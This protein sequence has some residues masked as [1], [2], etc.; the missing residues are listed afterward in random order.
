M[1]HADGGHPSATRLAAFGL[2]QLSA[3]ESALIEQHL[4]SCDSCWQQAGGLT[5][6]SLAGILNRSA[7]GTA[8]FTNPLSRAAG[9]PRPE[10]SD[11]AF[12]EPGG[13]EARL[14]AELTDHM[15][16]RV[17]G[18]L[19]FGGMGAVFKAEHRLMERP[20]ALKVI[21]QRLLNR[22][23]AVERFRREVKAAA[24]LNH[25]N[26]V[27]AYDA[28][29][30]GPLHFL[31]MEFVPGTSLARLVADRGPLS[32]REACD[33]VRQ[34]ALGL[35]HAHEHG[36]VHRDIKPQNLML[37]PD[38]QIKILDFGLAHFVSE[39]DRPPVPGDPE[40]AAAP[41][42]LDA[43]PGATQDVEG[44]D[45]GVSGG[46]LTSVGGVVGSP[47][48]IA[49]EQ[50]L[51]AHHADVRADI[52]SLGCT[53]YFLL[54]GRPPFAEGS[55]ADKLAAH[56]TQKPKALT[57]AR[58]GMP[59]SLSHVLDRMLA[60][61]PT[62]RYQ[63]PAEVVRALAP[64]GRDRRLRRRVALAVAGAGFLTVAALMAYGGIREGTNL[65]TV[66]VENETP[67]LQLQIVQD[68]KTVRV[69]DC[70][71]E[72]EARIK[73][74]RYEFHLLPEGMELTVSPA[75]AVLERDQ[76]V[77]VH[78]R[79]MPIGL[80]REMTHGAAVR[81]VAFSPDG[82]RGL[83]GDDGGAIRLW[84]LRTGQPVRNFTAQQSGSVSRVAFL[85]DGRQCLSASAD[86]LVR[87]WDADTGKE[88]RRFTGHTGGVQ[89][90]LLS[91]GGKK[92][93]SAGQDKVIREWDLESGKQL[94]TLEG[95]T[96]LVA[97]LALSSD[98]RRLLSGGNDLTIRLWDLASR[99]ELRQFH[100]HTGPVNTVA[101][102]PDGRRAVSA[103]GDTT[104]AVWDLE[105]GR[106]L[107]LLEL[108][109]S[110]LLAMALSPDGRFLLVGAGWQRLPTGFWEQSTESLQLWELETGRLV[111]YGGNAAVQWRVAFSPDGRYA[112]SGS[113]DRSMRLW[114]LP[115]PGEREGIL[116][117]PEPFV[118]RTLDEGPGY[119]R[120]FRGQ[121]AEVRRLDLSPGDAQLLSGGKDGTIQLFD[122]AT[123]R[124]LREWRGH[125]GGVLAVACAREGRHAL[126]GGADRLV[127]LWDIANG[128]ELRQFAG[129]ADPVRAVALS[130][131][132]KF[133]LSGGG[134]DDSEAK[135]ATDPDLRL[136]DVAAGT[137]VGRLKGHTDSVEHV[138]FSPDGK[139]AVS[140]GLDRAVRL[141]DVATRTEL[142]TL[143]HPDKVHGAAWSPDSR[144]IV[145][146]C[147]DGSLRL[148]DAA[149]GKEERVLGRHPGPVL[150]ATF[151][152]NGQRVVSICP[153]DGG[154]TLWESAT[155]K[156]LY[157]QSFAG[158][159]RPSCAVFTRNGRR[160]VMGTQ[161]GITQ[162]WQLP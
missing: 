32:V 4:M 1:Q 71:R 117:P 158:G 91:P 18:L 49:P 93:Y 109:N 96:D 107:R 148:W 39:F 121:W 128:E 30:V 134:F 72:T 153:V 77:T 76:T 111:R 110:G 81:A 51:D 38:G 14:P 64:F 58:S 37:T 54:T 10:V 42:A 85:P 11:T 21:S 69:L 127:R 87:L 60:K 142:R 66:R 73:P 151:S 89:D 137:E 101:F 68:E 40:A 138:A 118:S 16:Y 53:L 57:A 162:A 25:P 33:Y 119:V 86:R 90:V 145:S 144:K 43:D 27:A 92:L 61:D 106:R 50:I 44:N 5:Q 8:E 88:I 105:T 56:R 19:G 70:D 3:E 45:A 141:W 154:L 114:R 146:A 7:T 79:P 75:L 122:F 156:R 115:D 136:W 139:Q 123:G 15:R 22:P 80:V 160:V 74:G 47:D 46:T 59:S 108:Q 95:H 2:G 140:A 120:Q 102:L 98:G 133:A 36:M 52:Y 26:I 6:D 34:A 84:D 116:K 62:K 94:G 147:R 150:W 41:T 124:H 9:P 152:P 17:E 159:G 55:F 23:T 100:G 129:H 67:G 31:V 78:I 24:R 63:T 126:S 104:I 99:K 113:S 132:G 149:S 130:P 20:V 83:A 28:D 131:D 65:G 143:V 48:Y 103:A 125:E 161:D 155:G 13:H 157:Y 82:R 12:A 29:Q 97:C 35:Q 135:K 112:L